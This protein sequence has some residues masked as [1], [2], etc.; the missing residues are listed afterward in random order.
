MKRKNKKLIL[1]ITTVV[2]SI[3]LF[4]FAG[5][6]LRFLDFSETEADAYEISYVGSLDGTVVDIPSVMY[7]SKGSYPTTYYSGYE[8]KVSDLLGKMEPVSAEWE[9][10]EGTY[11]GSPVDVGDN[12]SF[13]FYGWYW[14][15]A[16][17]M[18]FNGTVSQK[19]VGDI[20]LYAKLTVDYWIGPY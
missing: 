5:I 2:S 8:T 17:T 14:D 7:S 3:L 19:P 9:G 6:A 1:K 16:C 4:L 20:K 10:F 18:E 15:K 11:V 12:K 13:S